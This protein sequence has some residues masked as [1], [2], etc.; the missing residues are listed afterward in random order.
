MPIVGEQ[1]EQVE[2]V[3]L[4]GMTWRTK[5][6]QICGIWWFEE[7]PGK[8]CVRIIAESLDAWNAAFAVMGFIEESDPDD[9][10]GGHPQEP[11]RNLEPGIYT[12]RARGTMGGLRWHWLNQ[13][14]TWFAEVDAK[15]Y[16]EL[17]EALWPRNIDLPD[18]TEF[19]RL[20]V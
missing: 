1:P 10:K 19:K 3:L 2:T 18:K 14:E 20:P 8:P 15:T 13:Q 9:Y 16:D 6:G 17:S 4:P 12:F 11:R 5:T 7:G